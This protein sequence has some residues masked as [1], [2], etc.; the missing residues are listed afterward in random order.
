VQYHQRGGTPHPGEEGVVAH[1][2]ADDLV[3]S[4]IEDQEVT[5]FFNGI[6]KGYSPWASPA[7]GRKR[8]EWRK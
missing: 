6:R 2:M 4:Y 3:L 5:E 7:S 8:L 1:L